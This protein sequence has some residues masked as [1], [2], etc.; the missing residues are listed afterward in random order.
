MVLWVEDEVEIVRFVVDVN[1]I[2]K[3]VCI[4]GV[5]VL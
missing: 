2:Y 3:V 1:V 4:V 5:G